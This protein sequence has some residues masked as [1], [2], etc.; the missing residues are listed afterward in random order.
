MHKSIAVLALLLTL[1][2]C[3]KP[4]VEPTPQPKPQPETQ[5]IQIEPIVVK[6]VEPPQ[7]VNKPEGHIRYDKSVELPGGYF[8]YCEKYPTRPECGGK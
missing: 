5:I 4:T 7:P 3:Y 6:P 1:A 8:D 2:A